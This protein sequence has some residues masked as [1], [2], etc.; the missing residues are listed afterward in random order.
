MDEFIGEGEIDSLRD[1][2]S[3]FIEWGDKAEELGE[4]RVDCKSGEEIPD[5]KF[6]DSGFGDRAFF[7]GDFRMKKISN[8]GAYGSG[9]EGG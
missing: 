1:I 7:P 8:E 2:E 6:I 9:N 5:K 3:E 4:E